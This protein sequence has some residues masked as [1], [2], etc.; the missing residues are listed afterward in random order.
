MGELPVAR[1][2][3]C[4]EP[5]VS[6]SVVSVVSSLPVRSGSD[7]VLLLVLSLSA[8]LAFRD[9]GDEP[10][11]SSSVVSLVSSL[12]VLSGS[13][14]VLL[15]C[16]LCSFLLVLGF[17]PVCGDLGELPVARLLTCD[18]P[19]VSSSV[20]SVVSSLPV[21]SGSDPVLLLVLPL[22]A[23]LAFRD[24]GDEPV[25]SSSV[26]S[27]VSS[28][29]VLSGSDPVLLVCVLR[30]LVLVLGV[31]PAC[32]D[33]GELPVARLLT[34][35]EPDVS[36][37]VVSVVF[38]LPV[39]SGSDPVL[40]LVLPLSALLAF[41]D[42][43]DEPVVS[44]SVVSLVSSLP[45]RS[46]SDPVLLLV[47]SLSALLAFRDLGDEPD[48][49]SSSVVSLVSSLP[50]RSGSD[51]VLLLV[52]PLSALLAFRDL[53]DE[54]VV[55]SSVVSLVSSLPV[56]SGSD[57][58]LL[59]CVLCSFLLVLGFL[60]VCGDLGELP[61]ARLLT[62]DEPDV[63]SSV[64]SVAS[65]LPVRSGSDPVLLLVLP[66]SALLAFRDLGDEPVVSS[67]VVSVVSS[68][69]VLSGSDPVLLVC[70]LR[71]LVLVLGFLPVCGDL[72]ELP[73]ALLR[74]SDEPDVS[75]SVVL[76][77]FSSLPVLSG[78][79]AKLNAL[80]DELVI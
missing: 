37:S 3:T 30:S 60:P 64:V 33:L 42:W 57:P 2:L 21:R 6:S 23:L 12:P 15:V 26:V 31:L 10:V 52:L 16:V 11:V 19:D 54:P 53:G 46:G 7:P 58:V 8:L 39:L 70:V 25:V 32:G 68:L 78:S 65:S 27:L 56:L 76:V 20:V 71:S 5:D 9:L 40:L 61:V 55:S 41:R 80:R 22:S 59:V 73:V 34:S 74:T 44:S 1:L 43:G 50:V 47:L 28:L 49:S 69:P 13:D 51:P 75:S 29:P 45:A 67:S 18:E 4:D 48:V 62:S 66:L 36:S 38:S 24:L 14:P 77:V 17:L 35:D 79:G 63:S 72:G